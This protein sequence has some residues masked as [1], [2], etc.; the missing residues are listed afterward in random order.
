MA[1]HIDAFAWSSTHASTCLWSTLPAEPSGSASRKCHSAGTYA[2]GT[3]LR[4]RRLHLERRRRLLAGARRGD[5]D[6]A[7][8]DLLDGHVEERREALER[9]TAS[10]SPSSMRTPP[11]LT[12]RSARPLYRSSPS[13][14]RACRGRPCGR[15]D[16]RRAGWG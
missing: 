15:A 16:P 3:S 2:A 14:R 8:V 6:E 1:P 13:P 11:T 7:L 12:C 9:T 5:A 4:E 10:I